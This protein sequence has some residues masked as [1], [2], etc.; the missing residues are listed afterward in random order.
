M[1][2]GADDADAA[3]WGHEYD[4][5]ED[6]LVTGTWT[7]RDGGTIK[8]SDMTLKHL[9]GARAV[10]LRARD[11][12]TFS[13]DQEKWQAWV[14]LFD[15]EIYVKAKNTQ[16]KPTAKPAPT[17]TEPKPAPQKPRGKMVRMKCHCGIEY[18]ARAADLKRGWGLSH[19]KSCAAI[20]RDFGR[21]AAKKIKVPT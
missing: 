3:G 20:R 2:Q 12:S 21:P 16:P 5:Y 6:G 19:D 10:A 7:M 17:S 1:G 18:D 8:V 13:C 14:D 11:R 15:D 9:Y 4:E